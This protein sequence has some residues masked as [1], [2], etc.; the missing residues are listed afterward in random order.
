VIP[1][2]IRVVTLDPT[3]PESVGGVTG[4]H[5]RHDR[6]V[7]LSSLALNLEVQANNLDSL[8]DPAEQALANLLDAKERR[9][10]EFDF[11]GI[12]DHV[13]DG[14]VDK[15]RRIV[16]IYQSNCARCHTSGYSAGVAFAQEAGSGGFGPALWDG[17]PAVQ[18]L[19]EE[20]LI[21]F[22]MNGAEANVPYGVNGFGNGQMPGFGA[23]LSSQDLAD[24]ARWLRAGNLTGMERQLM[25]E[26]MRDLLSAN[27]FVT[28]IILTLASVVIFF[29]SIYLLNYTN[30][31]KKLAFLVT[32]AGIFAGARS[33]R[34]CS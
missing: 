29:G 18:F 5:H 10:W 17:R 14:D 28:G 19:T 12:A 4:P 27:L 15:A 34:C 33:A 30:L 32:G 16:G 31:G 25:R 24:L 1:S 3:N 26:L 11:Q 23:D 20:D 13:F 7:G 21:D 22:I 6:G 8:L 9:A 2:E